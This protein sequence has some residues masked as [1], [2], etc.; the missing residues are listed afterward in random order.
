[1]FQEFLDLMALIDE[2]AY[3]MVQDNAQRCLELIQEGYRKGT[4][5]EQEIAEFFMIRINPKTRK[6]EFLIP[7]GTTSSGR[8]FADVISAR[9]FGTFEGAGDPI[10]L[11]LIR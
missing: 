6:Y 1:M 11:R 4:V 2:H 9:E 10:I 3:D 5:D 8:D 7:E